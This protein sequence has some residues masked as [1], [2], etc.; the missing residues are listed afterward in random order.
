MKN[1]YSTTLNIKEATDPTDSSSTTSD[2]SQNK[3]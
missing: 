3:T 1:V 2:K